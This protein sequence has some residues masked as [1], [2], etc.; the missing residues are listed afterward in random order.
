MEIPEVGEN[1]G[2]AAEIELEL[3]RARSAPF[4]PVHSKFEW[5]DIFWVK[6][7][8]GK[9]VQIFSLWIPAK[10]KGTIPFHPN[11]NLR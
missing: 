6:M 8:Y 11:M 7:H 10:T 4:F 3:E 5:C 1:G 2:E 9:L